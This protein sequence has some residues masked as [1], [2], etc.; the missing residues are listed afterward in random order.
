MDTVEEIFGKIMEA[1][2]WQKQQ[3]AD[4]IA[5]DRSTLSQKLGRHW[6]IHFRVFVRLLP[7]MLKLKIIKPEQLRL[8]NGEQKVSTEN[9]KRTKKLRQGRYIMVSSRAIPGSSY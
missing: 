8:D 3:L 2:N 9:N 5:V 6:N 7:F 1:Q 4:Y